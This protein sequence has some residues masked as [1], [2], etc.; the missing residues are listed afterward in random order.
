MPT[1]T[2]EQISE[3][4]SAF[5]AEQKNAKEPVTAADF[6]VNYGA[7]NPQWL[8]AVLCAH[9][10]GAKVLSHRLD[11]PDNGT[12]NRM[13]IFVDYNPA[14]KQAGLPERIFCKATH[15]LENRLSL[16]LIGA[17]RSE[18]NFYNQ[19][20]PLLQIEAPVCL[21]ANHNSALN[22]I[23]IMRELD[24][25]TVFCNYKNAE[26][27]RQRAEDQL[28]LLASLH[29]KF[30]ESAALK[31]TW[32]I[33]S[34][35]T[36]NFANM[37]YAAFEKACDK[38]FEMAEDIIA[39][40]L[41]A[42]RGE[43][44]PATRKSYRRHLQLPHTLTHGDAHLGNWYIT[45]TGAMGLSDWQTTN[46]GHWSRDVIYTLTTSLTV[47]RRR[48]WLPELLRYY[49]DQLERAAGRN[50][51]FDGLLDECRRQLF[52]VLAF[53]TITLNPAP[54]MPQMQPEDITRE[55]IRRICA[56]I[57]DLDALDSFVD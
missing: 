33:F 39:P 22:S 21:F 5:E 38:G 26:I 35:W 28:R 25:A 4:Y 14:G 45:P 53:W 49:H 48:Q 46:R 37:D 10:P 43:I 2:R 6:P 15:Q 9:V 11:V 31:S 47:E 56:A 34:T 3:A 42:R 8:T 12:S 55:F 17:A 16:G 19:L 18:V 13:R 32:Q 41:F 27:T 44:W 40:R 7:I 57:D 23:I 36:E 20:R 1:I 29:G 24:P 52:T 51:P 54:R 30:L 50:L